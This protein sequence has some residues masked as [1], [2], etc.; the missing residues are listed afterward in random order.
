MAF[1]FMI[2]SVLS[3][4]FHIMSYNAYKSLVVFLLSYEGK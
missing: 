4:E 2:D 3:Y 1:Y